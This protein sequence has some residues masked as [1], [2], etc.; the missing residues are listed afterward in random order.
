MWCLIC[1]LRSLG[2]QELRREAERSREESKEWLPLPQPLSWSDQEKQ[3]T[4][5]SGP[6]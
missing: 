1:G 6:C 5:V 3:E 2:P 4:V